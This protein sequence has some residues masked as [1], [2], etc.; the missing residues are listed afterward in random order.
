MIELVTVCEHNLEFV[1]SH[2]GRKLED[3][4]EAYRKAQS[5]NNQLVVAIPQYKFEGGSVYRF[6]E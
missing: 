6:G 4:T 3:L 5:L 2:T 1:A